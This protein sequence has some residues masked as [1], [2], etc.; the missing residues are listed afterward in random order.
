MDNTRGVSQNYEHRFFSEYIF[1]IDKTMKLAIQW[2]YQGPIVIWL[3]K[4]DVNI[5]IDSVLWCFKRQ[6]RFCGPS[7]ISHDIVM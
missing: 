1:K 6:I 5:D 2:H 4:A 7:Q 3:R